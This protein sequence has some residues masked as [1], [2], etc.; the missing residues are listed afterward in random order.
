MAVAGHHRF[1]SH[2]LPFEEQFVNAI[3]W[4]AEPEIVVYVR[5]S[6]RGRCLLTGLVPAA[7]QTTARRSTSRLSNGPKGNY[8]FKCLEDVKNQIKVYPRKESFH[9]LFTLLK[10][11]LMA[12][13][14]MASGDQ[15]EDPFHD[16][17]RGVVRVGPELLPDYLRCRHEADGLRPRSFLRTKDSRRFRASATRPTGTYSASL[18]LGAVRPRRRWR[19]PCSKSKHG[20]ARKILFLLPTMV[21]A[22]S[23]YDRMREFF[24]EHDHEVGLVHSTADLVRDSRWRGSSPRPTAQTY[25]RACCKSP[26]SSFR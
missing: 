7:L 3:A 2:D 22:N 24:D 21:T 6:W 8:P 10:G 17:E 12:A 23:I 26:T 13:D 1:V 11:L 19:G 15:G 20:H 16:V 18:P 4:I 14:W 9:D 25:G 5:D